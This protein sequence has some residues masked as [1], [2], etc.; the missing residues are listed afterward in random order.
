VS[1]AEGAAE[2]PAGRRAPEEAGAR[3][4][5]PPLI[6]LLFLLFIVFIPA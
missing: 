5:L 4:R 2:D 6:T 3:E 1:P